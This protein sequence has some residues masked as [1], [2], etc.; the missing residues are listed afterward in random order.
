M[1]TT[2]QR[3]LIKSAG[4]TWPEIA[5]YLAYTVVVSF[6]YVRMGYLFL[7]IGSVPVTILATAV[8]L[9]LS[10]RNNSAY[11][12]WWEARKIWGSV[13][14]QSRTFGMQAMSMVLSPDPEKG[15]SLK[16]QDTHQELIYRHLA[17]V[18]ALRLQLRNK[19]VLGEI[20]EFLPTKDTERIASAVNIATQ[21]N[22]LQAET[23]SMAKAQGLISELNF[24]SLQ[25]NLKLLYDFQGAAERIKNTPFPKIYDFGTRLVLW[26][27][28][29]L[30]P[31]ALLETFGYRTIFYS[32]VVSIV[33]IEVLRLGILMQEPFL[34]QPNDIPMTSICRNIE[35]DLRQMLGESV[36]PSPWKAENGVLM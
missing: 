34:D 24:I 8:T 29:L 14:N 22:F 6:L 2:F 16:A 17:Y 25:E 5:G 36:I 21:L 12:R 10:F 11:D 28:L 4:Y 9:L 30:L 1:I 19:E 26:V 32:C 7:S 35:I 33:F 23:L 27:F 20:R 3:S 18:N 15:V 31:F 13:I